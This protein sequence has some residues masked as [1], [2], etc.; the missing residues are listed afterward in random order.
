M[1]K[2]RMFKMGV[3][4]PSEQIKQTAKVSI[5]RTNL[6]MYL[7][8]TIAA[9]IILC[10]PP[11]MVFAA[12][13]HSVQFVI[14]KNIYIMNS[15]V[16]VMDAAPYVHK[17]RTFVPVRYLAYGLGIPDSGV[18]WDSATKT[19]T[20]CGDT[21]EVKLEIGQQIIVV[22][23]KPGY[24]DVAPV[25]KNRRTYLPARFIGEAFGYSVSWNQATKTVAIAKSAPSLEDV[26]NTNTSI[27]A[28][29][30]KVSKSVLFL[31]VYDSKGNHYKQ[32][33]CVAIDR[34]LVV[35]NYHV[36]DGGSSATIKGE[37]VSTSMIEGVIAYDIQSDLA[38]LKVNV[39]LT[40][41]ELGD[42]SSLRAGDKVV[43]IGNPQG[44]VGTVSDG[45]ISN[46]SRQLD[47]K[48]FLQFTAP[49]SPG[50]SGGGLF[51]IN[52]KLIG[53]TAASLMP[54]QAQNLNLAIPVNLLKPLIS[55]AATSNI[56]PL[57]QFFGPSYPQNQVA[58]QEVVDRLN[59]E[60]AEWYSSFGV[61]RFKFAVF[62]EGPSEY[63]YNVIALIEPSDYITWLKIYST[64]RISIM[65][66]LG[67]FF[68]QVT[69]GGLF[70]LGV[71]YCDYWPVYPAYF[72]PDEVSLCENGMWFVTHLIGYTYSDQENYYWNARP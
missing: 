5:K 47:G 60:M 25:I 44:L 50:S 52:A 63:D 38:I 54:G 24:M 32:G 65:R 28:V 13:S 22:D 15:V 31:E 30:A 42:S 45:I 72:D 26:E 40:R 17:G 67:E 43:A 59:S 39:N 12:S 58:V 16:C 35:T 46:V 9:M 7:L 3:M 66:Q 29:A 64:E 6:Y 69:N 71:F 62:G 49:V 55:V 53:I 36:I 68:N 48:Q 70:R 20:L 56:I 37:E 2:T 27:Q 23:G 11:G 41:V 33:S 61:I 51:D 4:K 19:I 8:L 57:N 1:F 21:K 34:N 18:K 14:D 10:L